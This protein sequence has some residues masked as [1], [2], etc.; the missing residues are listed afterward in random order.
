M[1]TKSSF[2]KIISYNGLI[3]ASILILLG[4]LYYLFDVNYFNFVFIG[5]NYLI[6]LTITVIFM[7]IGTHQ[8][9]DKV[10]NGKINYGYKLLT[11][12]LIGFIAFVVSSIFS[13]FFNNLV[14]SD[15]LLKQMDDFIYSMEERGLSEDQLMEIR[16]EIEMQFSKAYSLGSR[17]IHFLINLR[18]LTVIMAVISLI[19]A[20]IIKSDSTISKEVV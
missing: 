14:A 4:V 1:E 5:I 3:C 20:A 10:L 2:W 9:R 18:I 11:V 19:V 13:F 6:I 7:V 16:N 12:F 17:F 15:I 8:Y